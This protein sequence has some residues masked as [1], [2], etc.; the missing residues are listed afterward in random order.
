MSE[1]SVVV[2]SLDKD[3]VDLLLADRR[4]RVLGV[5]DPRSNQDAC[6]VPI[7]GDDAAWP[8]WSAQHPE[9]KVVLA[10]D[11]PPLRAKL[12]SHYGESNLTT[13]R[14]IQA[15]I[16]PFASLGNGCLVQRRALISAGVSVGRSV[17]INIGAMVHH[18]CRLGDFVTLGPGSRLLGSVIVEDEAYVGADATV[19]QG[20]RVG[21]GATIGAGAVVVDDIPPNTTVAGVPARPLTR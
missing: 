3:I 2:V 1:C 5:F 17:K 16:S 20:R 14:A 4:Y 11:A 18:D 12:H 10:V 19:L 21:A 7:L 9:V 8:T 6:G 13:V 15:D